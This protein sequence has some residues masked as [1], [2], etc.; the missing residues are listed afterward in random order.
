MS[1]PENHSSPAAASEQVSSLLEDMKRTRRL[2]WLGWKIARCLKEQGVEN[3]SG[4]LTI[5]SAVWLLFRSAQDQKKYARA[6]FVNVAEHTDDSRSA[7][8]TIG[9]I[10]AETASFIIRNLNEKSW[11][12]LLDTFQDESAEDFAEILMDYSATDFKIENEAPFFETPE[13]ISELAFSILNPGADDVLVDLGSGTG[14]FLASA[15]RNGFS[16]ALYGCDLNSEA[17]AI[18]DMRLNVLGR[19]Q[20]RV[21]LEN[22]NFFDL[23][24]ESGLALLPQGNRRLVFSN[25][26][27]D[28]P[29][30][31]ESAPPDRLLRRSSSSWLHVG[32]IV[33]IMGAQG[34]AVAVMPG[35]ALGISRSD[36]A[37]RKQFLDLGLIE[38]V[39][40]LPERLFTKT[41]IPVNLIVFSHGNTSV[42]MINAEHEFE[43]RRFQNFL[44]RA[45]IETILSLMNTDTKNSCSFSRKK[46]AENDDILSPGLYLGTQLTD[47]T[48]LGEVIVRLTRGAM[49]RASNLE[50]MISSEPTDIQ[51]LSTKNIQNGQIED[52]LPWLKELKNQWE[53][54]CI[55]DQA[56]LLTKNGTPFK[57]AVASVPA[58]KKILATANLYIIELDR[59]RVN[60]HFIRAF[61][62][63]TAGHAALKSVSGGT[64][65]SMLTS[66]ALKKIKIPLPPLPEQEKFVQSWMAEM[67]KV[68]ALRKSL[69]EAEKELEDMV[70]GTFAP[71]I[72]QKSSPDV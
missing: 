35:A 34:R 13:S 19:K 54:Y 9:G 23:A 26:S 49:L 68:N 14:G 21:R 51:Y 37:I 71:R 25:C 50:Q 7:Q 61:L 69:A 67:I 70:E 5:M 2:R 36:A 8:N 43:S 22:K 46:I 63:S 28:G 17:L 56:L 47:G 42:R 4:D 60:P 55:P 30:V 64:V 59:T 38:C 58:G 62:N 44:S 40:A 48:P 24:D 16:G 72:T 33:K 11:N 1:Q 18:A 20:E 10:S 32:L 39:I 27:W 53:R 15:V 65:I 31:S 66:E 12:A 52:N 41:D 29:V 57:A 45:N 6:D 3:Y